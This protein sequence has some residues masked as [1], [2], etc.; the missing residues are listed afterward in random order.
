MVLLLNQRLQH[1]SNTDLESTR[2]IKTRLR[3]PTFWDLTCQTGR[4]CIMTVGVKKWPLASMRLEWMPTRDFTGISVML[5]RQ[6]TQEPTAF[7]SLHSPLGCYP[8]PTD[9]RGFTSSIQTFQPKGRGT[10]TAWSVFFSRT[11]PGTWEH[12]HS[13]PLARFPLNPMWPPR[14]KGW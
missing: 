10:E 8:H 9:Q 7:F 13:F 11:R 4:C 3:L 6:V 14:C 1:L 5:L 12:F 2:P